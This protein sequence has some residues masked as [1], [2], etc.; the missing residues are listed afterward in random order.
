MAYAV[1]TIENIV[2]PP[3]VNALTEGDSRNGDELPSRQLRAQAEMKLSDNRRIG[4]SD[5]IAE[6]CEKENPS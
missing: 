6:V 1:D 5:E 4:S 3:E 2:E